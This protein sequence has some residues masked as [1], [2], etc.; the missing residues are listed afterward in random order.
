MPTRPKVRTMSRKPE[1]AVTA[2]AIESDP[3]WALLKARSTDADGTFFYTVATT[4]IVCRPACPSRHPKPENVRFHATL[5]E[6]MRL[7][8]RPCKRCKPEAVSHATQLADKIAKACRLIEQAETPPTLA[9]L[10]E[11]AGL[12]TFHFHRQF[13]ALFHQTPMQFLHERRLA[14]ARTLLIR[15]DEPVT[16]ICFLVGL[17]SLGSFCSSFRKRF[18]HSPSQYRRLHERRAN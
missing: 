18:G 3:R 16:N 10:A 5:D 4:G 15:T 2:A 8:F 6:A 11:A 9:E 14:A 1:P 12:S 17:E 7:G 13:K